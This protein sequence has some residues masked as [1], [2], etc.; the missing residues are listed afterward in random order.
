MNITIQQSTLAAA[1]SRAA[2]VAEKK[3]TSPLL[4]CAL[5]VANADG[6]TVTA[7]D[8]ALTYTGAYPAEVRTPGDVAVPA[9]TLLSTVKMLPKG[10]VTLA[11]QANGK[12]K[13]TAG[14]ATYNVN[15]FPA[16]DFPPAPEVKDTKVLTIDAAELR[17]IL[18]QTIKAVAP[19]DNRYGLSG[20]HV[21]KLAG[22]SLS[23]RFV[24]TDGNRLNYADAAYSGELGIGRKMLLPRPAAVQI[25]ALIDGYEGG[26]DLA[27]GDRAAVFTIPGVSLIIRLLEADFPDY[28]QVLPSA[29]KRRAFVDRASLVAALNRVAIFATDGAHTVSFAFMGDTL[30]LSARK[31]D[32]GDAGDEVAIDYSG[33]NMTTGFNVRFVLDA[34]ATMAGQRVVVEMG[35]AL[36]PCIL[37][38]TDEERAR[39]IVMPVRL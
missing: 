17:R 35:D 20:I 32:A 4:T 9:A 1:L 12:I 28:R 15:A 25:R 23:L 14:S 24:A 18:D 37:R 16:V 2:D 13:V 6:I 31:L 36:S 3:T 11:L 19:D 29:Y 38:D 39:C 22:D 34:L 30:N 26:V 33:D 21:E 8:K 27:F 10:P 5:I 7:T